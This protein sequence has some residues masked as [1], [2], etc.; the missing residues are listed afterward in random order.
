MPEITKIGFPAGSLLETPLRME[1][2]ACKNGVYAVLNKPADVLFDS[3]LGAPKCKSVMQALRAQEGKPELCRLG[4]KSPYSVCQIDCEMS[5]AALFAMDK[6][7]SAK[8]RNAAWS[9]MF[10]LSYVFLARRSQADDSFDVDLPVYLPEEQ[11]MWVVSHRFG[12]KAKTSFRR[13]DAS[14]DYELWGATTESARP[15]QLRVHAADKGLKIVGE[16]L[17]AKGGC[18]YLSSIKGDYRLPTGAKK[19]VPLYPHLAVHLSR[20][21]MRS[22]DGLEDVG[23]IDANAPLPKGFTVMLKKLGFKGD[24]LGAFLSPAV[25]PN[26]T[27]Q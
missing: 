2:A 8:L 11:P 22:A 10:E 26:N 15:H 1:V 4:I 24:K 25:P 14:G 12:K 21:K 7:I 17:Y 13:I 5:G 3:Y 19:E 16:T 27:G 23:C 9:G 18:V 6:E 20:I